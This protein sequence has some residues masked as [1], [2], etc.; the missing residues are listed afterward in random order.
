MLRLIIV[1]VFLLSAT[2][3]AQ[4]KF[5]L[6]CVANEGLIKTNYEIIPKDAVLFIFN[7]KEELEIVHKSLPDS[8][9]VVTKLDEN[10]VQKLYIPFKNPNGKITLKLKGS[11]ILYNLKYGR[12]FGVRESFPSV[13]GGDIVGFDVQKK[14]KLILNETTINYDRVIQVE[15]KNDALIVVK[16]PQNNLDISIQESDYF[17]FYF[18]EDEAEYNI[19]VNP[20]PDGSNREII[21]KKEGYINLKIPLNKVEPKGFRVFS[22]T[23]ENRKPGSFYIRSKPEGAT[24]ELVAN[25]YF[26][27]N[28]FKTPHEYKGLPGYYDVVLK[29]E[30]YKTFKG[31][32][33][34]SSKTDTIY[35]EEI[36]GYLTIPLIGRYKDV[37]VFVDNNL[38]GK[39]PISNYEILEGE[40]KIKLQTDNAIP[41]QPFYSIQIT[42]G[43]HNVL[44]T[45][46]FGSKKVISISTNVK[47]KVEL[48]VD[49]VFTKTNNLFNTTLGLH[50][51]EFIHKDYDTL[52]TSF[53][54]NDTTSEYHFDLKPKLYKI[55]FSPDPK[56]KL[57]IDN[58]EIGETPQTYYL[59]KGNAKVVYEKRGYSELTRHYSISRNQTIQEELH[60]KM[61][62]ILDC[63]FGLSQINGNIGFLTGKF[64]FGGKFGV[65]NNLK[66]FD[67]NEIEF[68]NRNITI[69]DIQ[70][71]GS[72]LG[73][74]FDKD[75]KEFSYGI[76]LGFFT[77]KP[78]PLLF[79]GSVTV[80]NNDGHRFVYRA[81]KDYHQPILNTGE[82]FLFSEI[83]NEEKIVY[84]GGVMLF[85]SKMLFIEAEYYSDSFEG[86]GIKYGVGLKLGK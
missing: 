76:R 48:Y 14:N 21:L 38:I 78:L 59:P 46:S 37:N 71:Y 1:F 29:K 15:T 31:N 5:A 43:N 86:P 45:Y 51:I 17:S 41:N 26:S 8:M 13:Q 67:I 74:V 11:D 68:N 79:F 44:N 22:I 2:C 18:D 58:K 24:I 50:D 57:Y 73:K 81:N 16:L 36:T 42:E 52:T 64:Y 10:N 7:T 32:I 28:K 30:G 49:G 80:L 9:V 35:L 40:H 6:E 66:S 84:T 34:I 27:E 62:T 54:V 23:D 56:C 60:A 70:T 20:N 83:S 33:N 39:L 25:K 63:S 61:S 19:L 82:V 4:N 55:T 12:H 47:K 53:V 3:F 65:N 85:L 69:D 77:R 75:K 72:N